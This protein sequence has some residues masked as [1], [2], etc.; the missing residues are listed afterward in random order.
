MV[1]FQTTLTTSNSMSAWALGL[2]L[3]VLV[4]LPAA[5]PLTTVGDECVNGAFP[6]TDASRAVGWHVVNLED[7]PEVR[8]AS[9]IKAKRKEIAALITHIKTVRSYCCPLCY[10]LCCYYDLHSCA[11]E[12]TATKLYLP[13]CPVHQGVVRQQHPNRDHRKGLGALGRNHAISFW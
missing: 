6:P 10:S 2:A 3:F 7:A 4:S 9:L 11:D 5:L 13:L 8:W 1:V 12:V